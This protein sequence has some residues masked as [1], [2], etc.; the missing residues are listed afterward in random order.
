MKLLSMGP[1]LHCK[2]YKAVCLL[3]FCSIWHGYS[4]SVD[5]SSK[6]AKGKVSGYSLSYSHLLSSFTLGPR[7]ASAASLSTDNTNPHYPLSG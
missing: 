5:Q 6:V 7:L 4:Y 1:M 3:L 2:M